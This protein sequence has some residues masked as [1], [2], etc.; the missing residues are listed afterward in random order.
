[1]R[2]ERRVFAG[3]KRTFEYVYDLWVNRLDV[4]V[5]RFAE[6]GDPIGTAAYLNDTSVVSSLDQHIT[7]SLAMSGDSQVYCVWLGA[8]AAPSKAPDS[9]LTAS[10]DFDTFSLT[11]IRPP[12]CGGGRGGDGE[13]G[14]AALPAGR[15]WRVRGRVAGR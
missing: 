2:A 11:P 1:V 5:R 13:A 10:F 12:T 4:L 15:A 3:E 8:R 9:V 7:P 6:D 14:R